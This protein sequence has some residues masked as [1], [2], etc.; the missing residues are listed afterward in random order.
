MMRR[1]TRLAADQAGS[2]A[3]E[4]AMVTPILLA[5]MFGAFELGNFFLSE[6]VVQKGVRDA[7]R[8]AAR[9]SMTNYPSCSV[10]GPAE[11]QI[12]RVARTGQ[13][14]GT[15]LRLRGWTA[16]SMTTVTLECDSSGTFSGIYTDFPNGV[17]VITVS[18]SVPYPSL[19]GTLGLGNPSLTV[20]A[21]S[22]SAVFGA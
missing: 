7:A 20:N 13:P 2:A 8:Y 15:T 19:F 4:M 1:R 22:Q 11:T 9:L 14:D 10:S 12:Q 6:H 18:A 17:P 16:D 5:L 3:A 21:R